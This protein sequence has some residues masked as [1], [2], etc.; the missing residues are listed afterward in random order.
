L[1]IVNVFINLLEEF[2]PSSYQLAFSLILDKFK[3]I[4]SPAFLNVSQ[5]FFKDELTSSLCKYLID[6]LLILEEV[7][8]NEVRDCEF[9]ETDLFQREFCQ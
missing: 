8:V 3:F 7:S 2:V 1:Q 6:N 4:L 9:I 5:E